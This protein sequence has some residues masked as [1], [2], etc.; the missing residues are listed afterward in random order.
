MG[1]LYDLRAWR[2]LRLCV[3][4]RDGWRCRRCGRAGALEAHHVVRGGGPDPLDPEGIIT[5]CRT[6]HLTETR[7]ERRAGRTAAW[8]ALIRM[9]PAS[10]GAGAAVLGI[11]GGRL[12]GRLW[13]DWR[14]PVCVVPAGSAWAARCLRPMWMFWI[15]RWRGRW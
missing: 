12:P 1:R 14:T 11:G 8:D 7:R 4:E 13:L 9:C 3:L 6:C 2:R 15:G 5:L 10:P